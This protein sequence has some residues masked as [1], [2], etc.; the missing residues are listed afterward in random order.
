MVWLKAPACPNLSVMACSLFMLYYVSIYRFIYVF[1]YICLFSI[2]IRRFTGYFTEHF[3]PYGILISSVSFFGGGI[4][5]VDERV[6]P[7][8]G[9]LNPW[10]EGSRR[11]WVIYL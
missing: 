5:L 3:N 2:P 7:Q 6:E 9:I 10:G 8:I 11:G 4:G 1:C